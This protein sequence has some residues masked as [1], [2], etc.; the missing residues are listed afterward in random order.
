MNS[1]VYRDLPEQDKERLK[2]LFGEP[3]EVSIDELKRQGVD[4]LTY[5]ERRRDNLK[6]QTQK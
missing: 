5:F 4:K 1:E 3:Q 2:E 6:P